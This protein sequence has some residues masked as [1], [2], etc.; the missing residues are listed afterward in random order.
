MTIWEYT[1]SLVT[2]FLVGLSFGMLLSVAIM[3][4][5]RKKKLEAD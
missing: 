5:I 1:A 2:A 4:N 3:A